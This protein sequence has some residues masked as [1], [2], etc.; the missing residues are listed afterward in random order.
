M[1]RH[2]IRWS[3]ILGIAGTILLAV[4]IAVA[5]VLLPGIEHYRAEFETALAHSLKRPV[6]IGALHFDWQGWTPTLRADAISV[7]DPD[8]G[9]A[10]FRIATAFISIAPWDSLRSGAIQPA[11]LSISG[12]QLPLRRHADGHFS[13]AGIDLVGADPETSIPLLTPREI[14]LDKSEVWWRDDLLRADKPAL[15]FQDASLLIGLGGERWHAQIDARFG[16]GHIDLRLDS[17][18]AFGTRDTGAR[19]YARLQDIT[20][21]PWSELGVGEIN[22]RIDG[23]AWATLV[24]NRLVSVHGRLSVADISSDK[25]P[26]LKAVDGEFQAT[27]TIDGWGAQFKSLHLDTGEPPRVEVGLSLAWHQRDDGN[28]LAVGADTVHLPRWQTLLRDSPLLAEPVAQAIRELAPQGTVSALTAALDLAAA[29]TPIFYLEAQ[30]QEL[31]NSAWSGIPGITGLSGTLRADADGANLALDSRNVEVR[32]PGLF[33]DPLLAN[34]LNGLVTVRHTAQGWSLNTDRIDLVNADIATASRFDIDIDPDGDTTLRLVSD[35]HDGD[36]STVPTYL[37]AG[38]MPE[39]AV[40]WLD[41]GIVSGHVLNGG[42]LFN[43]RVADFPFEDHSGRFEVRFN[44]SDVVVD[45]RQGWPRIEEIEAETRFINKRLEIHAVGGKI[46]SVDL[47]KVAAVVPDLLN[48]ELYI[49]GT[50]RGAGSE[51][52]RFLMESPLHDDFGVYFKGM[53]LGGDTELDLSIYLPLDTEADMKVQGRIGFTDNTLKVADLGNEFRDMNGRLSFTGNGLF[54]KGVTATLN[55]RPV[56]V[57]VETDPKGLVTEVELLANANLTELLGPIAKPLADQ[58]PGRAD[59]HTTLGFHR[60]KSGD[61]KPDTAVDVR[62]DLRGIAIS[63]PP[64]FGKSAEA[65]RA[66]HISSLVG[67]DEPAP[68]RIRY[69]DNSELL[70]ELRNGSNGPEPRAAELRLGGEQAELPSMEGLQIRGRLPE[71]DLDSLLGG[72]ENPAKQSTPNGTT[73]P[74]GLE[75][76]DLALNIGVLKVSGQRF[77]DVEL[78]AT[79]TADGWHVRLDGREV[80]GEILLPQALLDDRETPSARSQALQVQLDRL[81]LT[82]KA[83]SDS[84]T[85]ESRTQTDPRNLPDLHVSIRE[86]RI[87]D[88]NLG[89]IDVDAK[90][91]A[92]G[93]EFSRIHLDNGST[94][95]DGQGGWRVDKDGQISN[96]S[97]SLSSGELGQTLRDFG[98]IDVIDGGSG[99]VTLRGGWIGT[100]GDFSMRTFDGNLHVR[101][102]DGRLLEVDPGAGGRVFG[103]FSLTALPRRLRLD[104]TDLF[105]KGFSFDVIEGSFTILDGDAHTTDL[106]LRGPPAQVDIAGRTGFA[107]RVYDQTV[108]VTPHVGTTVAAASALLNPV[109]GAAVLVV[110]KLLKNPLDKASQFQYEMRGPWNNP[111]IERLNPEADNPQSGEG[112][113]TDPNPRNPFLD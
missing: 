37:P 9:D 44:A 76:R 113:G 109:V 85:A 90:A 39:S 84:P 15:Q 55:Q 46:F 72:A 60:L 112:T 22:G 4:L 12:V 43:G 28:W 34:R 69:G 6:S 10:D 73:L 21:P 103:L 74:K 88:T 13:V 96:L 48:S 20:L 79:H 38:I 62:S 31:G 14:S 7:L 33:R 99:L 100:P 24:G 65:S 107:D 40:A 2:I 30:L 98:F 23:E 5:R 104:F 11:R 45:Y 52:M 68:V 17:D 58:F 51:M 47:P 82:S 80:Q 18:R 77:H 26:A 53:D 1:H 75:P 64:P 105:K 66:L 42:V 61:S 81:H 89:R 56:T 25:L 102:S 27:R 101:F 110:N 108:T 16:D 57:N 8:E 29:E 59:W 54:A 50:A 35:F 70:I 63:A 83:D 87:D 49:N 97:L 67:V 78:N 41:R 106:T 32:F 92:N 91:V 71:L 19:A 95:G 111:V 94:Q 86:L 3:L 93:L 36:A